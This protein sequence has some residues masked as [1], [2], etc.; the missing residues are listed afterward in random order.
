MKTKSKKQVL[1]LVSFLLVCIFIFTSLFPLNADTGKQPLTLRDIM[2]FKSLRDAFIS[3]DGKWVVYHVKP[4]RGDGEVIVYNI[5]S[6]KTTIIQPGQK[7]VMTADSRWVAAA[8]EPGERK[9]NITMVLLDTLTSQH[10]TFENVKSFTF[11]ANSQWLIYRLNSHDEGGASETDGNDSQDRDSEER[12]I[13]KKWQ[14]RTFTLILRHLLT[15]KQIRI[16][17]VLYYACD[18]S[19]RYLAYCIYG[20]EGQ[21]NGLFVLD[22]SKPEAPGIEILSEPKAL[23][24]GLTWSPTKSRLA[25]IFHRSWK[26]ESAPPSGVGS[27]KPAQRSSEVVTPESHTQGVPMIVNI[28]KS[29][30]SKTLLVDLW[31]R[32]DLKNKIKGKTRQTLSSGLWIWDGVNRTLHGAVPRE[33]IP[34]GWMI[35]ADN[36]LRW[37]RDS[38][39]LF[40]GLKPYSEYL[41]TIPGKKEQ[42]NTDEDPNSIRRIRENRTVDVWHWQ[43]PLVNL[44]QKK[45]WEAFRKKIYFAVYHFSKNLLILLAMPKVQIPENPHTVLGFSEGPY[46]RERSWDHRYRDVYLIDITSGF[47]GKLLT[48]HRYS[49]QVSMSPPGRFVVYYHQKHW[50]LYDVRKKSTRILTH[51]L[52]TPFFNEDYDRPGDVP[53]YGFAGWTENGRSVIIYDKYDIW[54]F[55]TDPKSD[56][57]LCLT[58]GKGRREKIIFRIQSA[59]PKVSWFNF[60]KHQECLLTAF[61]E[62]EKHTAFYRVTIG[63]PGVHKLFEEQGKTF[64]FLQESGKTGRVIYTRESFEEFPDIWVSDA[65]FT[66]PEKIS[67]INPQKEKFLWGRSQLLEWKSLDGKPLQGV[68]I[69]PENFQESKRYPLL[70]F[71]YERFSQLLHEFPRMAINNF[72]CLPYYAGDGYVLFLPDIRFE[73]GKPGES[74][75][76]CIVPGVKKLIDMG[77]VDADAIGIY[78]HSWGGYLAVNMITRTDMFSAAVA[79]A[80]VSNLTSAYNAV[81]R[82]SGLPRQYHYEKSQGRMG[83][84]LWEGLDLYIENSPL[85]SAHRIKTPLLIEFGDNDGVVP[86]EQGL[87]LYLALRRLNKPCIFLQYN[88]ESHHLK[89]YGNKLD[90]VMRMKEFLDYYLRGKEAKEWIIK[91]EPYRKK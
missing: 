63:K 21:G 85:F 47:Q 2:T 15:A 83:K 86:W 79:G 37:T 48:R 68:V 65:G 61:S 14:T 84:S 80:P 18:P 77:M 22:L 53:G 64:R 50:F 13:E 29:P 20:P 66:S 58:Q 44:H 51:S 23:F 91:G 7:P 27:R 52:R 30:T 39:R 5:A 57:S 49:H 56:Q 34:G 16:D 73:T 70:V 19:S 11:S 9:P 74:A 6:R 89:A 33:K 46:L 55:F 40:F 1:F 35:P 82:R 4:D 87:E 3:E 43:D 17:Q 72:P 12:K 24:T 10:F 60:K 32:R 88:D 28:P 54:E 45:R 78:G 42:E 36:R 81:R 76:N 67:D 8:V 26:Q 41:Q 69:T 59:D 31:K 25:F 62:K 90:Y 38:E 75:Y 71:C